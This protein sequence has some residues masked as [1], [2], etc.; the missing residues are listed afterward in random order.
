MRHP[1][2]NT[3]KEWSDL[4]EWSFYGEEEYGILTLTI[5]VLAMACI[6]GNYMKGAAT[7]WLVGKSIQCETERD[8]EETGCEL[9]GE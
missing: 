4:E 3:S 6:F 2:H 9:E 7:K 5:V 1:L 8:L